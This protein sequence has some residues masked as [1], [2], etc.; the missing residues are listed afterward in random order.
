MALAEGSEVRRGEAV[1]STGQSTR[2]V[3]RLMRG[4]FPT[5]Q[6]PCV[7]PHARPAAARSA[8]VALHASSVALACCLS[9]RRGASSTRR[10]AGATFR[11]LRLSRGCAD[12]TKQGD[13]ILSCDPSESPVPRGLRASRQA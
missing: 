12:E 9:A 3:R 8:G 7:S 1:D 10:L 13:L 5:P 4:A 6:T 2:Q 11:A